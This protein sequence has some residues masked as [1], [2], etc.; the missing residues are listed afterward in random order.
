MLPALY[1]TQA[2]RRKVALLAGQLAL[3]ELPGD[4]ERF[5]DVGEAA[6]GFFGPGQKLAA[7]FVALLGAKQKSRPQADGYDAGQEP[8]S[9]ARVIGFHHGA[10]SFQSSRAAPE[11]R[12]AA[13]QKLYSTTGL[14]G[15]HYTLAQ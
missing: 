8:E 14:G 1:N 15:K 6:L 10:V 7:D 5:L 11:R 13:S 4:F 2:L 9:F 12:R 3:T